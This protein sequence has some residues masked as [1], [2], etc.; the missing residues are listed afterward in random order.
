MSSAKPTHEAFYF[1][2]HTNHLEGVRMGKWKLS[3]P[4]NSRTLDGKPGGDE[5]KETAYV[6]KPV[7][8]ALYDLAN[9]PAE[10]TDV[11][12]ANPEVL[13][14]MLAHVEAAREELGDAL[15]KREGSGRR[16]VGRVLA[17]PIEKSK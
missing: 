16:A 7:P 6:E 8:R 17:A 2:Y 5:G 1:Y 15:T 12:A 9:D 14:E 3:L 11:S 4:R 13:A 10:T